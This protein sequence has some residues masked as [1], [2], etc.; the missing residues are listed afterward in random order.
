MKVDGRC[1]CGYITYEAELDPEKILICNCTDCQTLSGSAFRVV[2]YTREDAFKLLSGDL[3]IYVKTSESGNKRPQS[4]CAQCGA[5]I[6]ATADGTGPKVYALRVGSIRQRDQLAPTVQV[7]SR[8]AQPWIARVGSMPKFAKQPP[9]DQT[10][11]VNLRGAGVRSRW[12][13]V[14]SRG[15]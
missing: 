6:Y 1:H 10:G 11:K 8:S 5:P 9:I 4:F 7:W 14:F 2:A 13:A 12:I 15:Q 3:K